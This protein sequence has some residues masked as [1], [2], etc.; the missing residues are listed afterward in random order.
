M[1]MHQ[2]A[3]VLFLHPSDELYGA[4]TSLLY[5]LRGL[6]RALFQPFVILAN[7]L[8]YSGLLSKELT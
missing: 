2:P 1:T 6:D 4:D 7:D 8:D 5:L 3:R